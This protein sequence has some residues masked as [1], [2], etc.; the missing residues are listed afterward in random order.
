MG[1]YKLPI[2]GMTYS[3]TIWEDMWT[4]G[5]VGDLFPH[6]GTTRCNSAG[7]LLRWIVEGYSRDILLNAPLLA[8]AEKW[9]I[10][11]GKT[12]LCRMG[13]CPTSVTL[14]CSWQSDAEGRNGAAAAAARCDPCIQ[15]HFGTEQVGCPSLGHV[16]RQLG[17]MSARSP[18][19]EVTKGPAN[20]PAE[21]VAPRRCDKNK[22][23]ISKFFWWRKEI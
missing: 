21:R 7:D 4:I 12:C 23:F 1:S 6:S 3:A 5:E 14:P 9:K 8:G 20:I 19:R 16:S 2:T 13:Q 17:R 18:G 22:V 11:T 15:A 10:R